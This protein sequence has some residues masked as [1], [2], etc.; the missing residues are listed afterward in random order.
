VAQVLLL[1]LTVEQVVQAVAVLQHP[2]DM[3]KMR[4]LV[5]LIK[6]TQGVQV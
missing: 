5:L 4:V 2:L 6:V 3:V 1:A